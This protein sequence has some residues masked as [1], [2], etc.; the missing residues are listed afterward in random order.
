MNK[1]KL[2]D[3]LIYLDLSLNT[4][5]ERANTESYVAIWKLQQ[6]YQGIGDSKTRHNMICELIKEIE[7]DIKWDYLEHYYLH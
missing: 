5:H 6:K 2:I 4:A 1:E 3:M 7:G